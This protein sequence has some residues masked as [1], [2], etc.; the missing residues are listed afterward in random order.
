MTSVLVV[1]ATG[2]QGG[3]VISALLG[4]GRTDLTIKALTRNT[5]SAPAQTL[6]KKGVQ[7][8]K[9]DLLD[10]QSL[11]N[12]L[13]DVDVAYLVTDF[14]GPGDIEGE[15]KQGKQ[16]VDVAKE[17]GV[18]HI[19][20]SSVAG[21]DISKPVDHF[22]TKYLLEEYIKQSGLNWTIVRPVGF[23]EVLPPPGIGRF[24]FMSA[25]ASLMG[26]TKQK[27][28]A[29]EDIGKAVAAALINPTKFSGR[30]VTVAGE[31]A[32]VDELQSALEKG[33]GRKGWGRIWLPRWII[34]R[35]T[36]HHYR[37]MFDWLFYENCQPG[38]PEETKEIVP[39]LLSIEAWARKQQAE[40]AI[41]S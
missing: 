19:V 3:G 9:G 18:K 1:G 5:S 28:V 36:P 20:F 41:A 32:N 37:Q 33:E 10:R 2:Q 4:Y 17:S 21:A 22:Y 14:R 35:L 39:D 31:I 16:F 26:D 11:L 30:V 27:Y 6:S 12:A 23:M 24:F 25:M 7:L 8:C 29:C 13:N 38:S 34:I 15:M 40:R